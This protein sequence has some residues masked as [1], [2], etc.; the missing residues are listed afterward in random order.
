MNRRY[1]LKK[2]EEIKKVLDY[3]RKKISGAITVYTKPQD[4]PGL[5]KLA[6]SVPKK[7]GNA[8][9]RNKIKRQLREILRLFQLQPGIDY[10]VLVK[11]TAKDYTFQELEKHIHEC[12]KQHDQIKGEKN[13]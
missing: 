11:P 2:N 12:L 9:Q 3:Q 1:S 6:I 8:V 4:K 5:F 7:Y 10:F 13:E